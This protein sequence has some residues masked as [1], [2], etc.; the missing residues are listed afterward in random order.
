MEYNIKEVSN[1]LN[2]S[3]EMIRYYEKKG[4]IS[5]KRKEE[6]N[7]RSY[8]TMDVFFL[9]EAIQYQGWNINIKNIRGLKEEN[10]YDKIVNYLLKYY[11]EL[12]KDIDYKTLLSELIC[13]VTERNKMVRYNLGN[14]WV[15]RIPERYLFHV[16]TGEGDSYEKICLPEE[17]SKVLFSD[18]NI[19]FWDVYFEYIDGK[20][21]WE[22]S[23][24][25][26][27]FDKLKILKKENMLYVPEEYCLCTNVNLGVIGAFNKNFYVDAL[28]YL[29]KKGYRQNG[30]LSA[31]LIGRGMEE[32]GFYRLIELHIPIEKNLETV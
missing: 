14:Y 18:T 3:R 31:L 15:K 29:E 21:I 16:V 10:Y 2:I 25:K 22:L 8:D 30:T 6:N 32:D 4:M 27:Y 17:M 19:P 5:P 20:E 7:Y 9:M 1:I 12:I 28:D 26:R 11:N 23:F 13:Q 24:E